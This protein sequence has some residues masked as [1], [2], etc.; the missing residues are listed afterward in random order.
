MC[1]GY[2]SLFKQ[3]IPGFGPFHQKEKPG[4]S[5]NIFIFINFHFIITDENY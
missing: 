2:K 1:H 3:T 4:F 5:L